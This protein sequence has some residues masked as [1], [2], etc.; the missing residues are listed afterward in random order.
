MLVESGFIE[1]GLIHQVSIFGEAVFRGGV[2]GKGF[3]GISQID[4]CSFLDKRL[5]VLDQFVYFVLDDRLEVI[6]FLLRE[7]RKKAEPPFPMN[8][9]IN[10][11]NGCSRIGKQMGCERVFVPH[12]CTTVDSVEEVRIINVQLVWI[13]TDDWTWSTT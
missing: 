12:A 13:Y 8:V 4:R 9:M 6:D 5:D 7:E 3:E 11:T 10:S 2:S 1:V